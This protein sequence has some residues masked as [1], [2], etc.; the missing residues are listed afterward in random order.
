MQ[1][2]RI[3]TGLGFAAAV[4]VFLMVAYFIPPKTTNASQILRALVSIMAG[5]AGAFLTGGIA[6]QINGQISDGLN[7]AL[8]ASG[9]TG[10]F[11]LIWLTWEK[12][13]NTPGFHIAFPVGVTF[14]AAAA[15]IGE[16]VQARVH[17]LGFT[18][19][20]SGATIVTTDLKAR[21]PVGALRSLRDYFAPHAIRSYTVTEVD[22]GFRLSI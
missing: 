5:A 7:I 4:V 2:V 20:E 22:G 21:D 1:S 13:T 19:A 15:T 11:V 10:L 18:P 16:A 9:G 3:W 6:I 12:V 14:A 8:T 17:M